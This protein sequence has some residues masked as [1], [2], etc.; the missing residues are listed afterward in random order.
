MGPEDGRLEASCDP[1]ANSP[2]AIYLKI[3]R[4]FN[5]CGVRESVCFRK[6]IRLLD[7]AQ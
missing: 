6:Q 5:A 1:L 4:T 2:L 7:Q 3:A